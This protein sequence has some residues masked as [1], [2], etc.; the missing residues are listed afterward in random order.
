M[1]HIKTELN[2]EK[3]SKQLRLP[4]TEAEWNEREVQLMEKEKK[5]QGNF[6]RISGIHPGGLTVWNFQS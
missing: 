6:L 1:G 5:M 3:N 4:R 2:E